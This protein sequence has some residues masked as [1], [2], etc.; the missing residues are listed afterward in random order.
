MSSIKKLA[1]DLIKHDALY[2][3]GK[4]VISDAEYDNLKNKVQSKYPHHPVFAELKKGV[5]LDGLATPIFTEWYEIFKDKPAVVVQPKI[6]GCAILLRY[7]NGFLANAWTR[8]GKDKLY[9]LTTV[10]N[11]PLEIKDKQNDLLIRGELYGVHKTPAYSQRLASGHLRKKD[12][13][14]EGLAF[15]AFEI[16]DTKED[17][18]KQQETLLSLGFQSS[19]LINVKSNVVNK[20]KTL[21]TQWKNSQLFSRFP[22]DGIVVRLA[23]RHR[24]IKS[25][26]NYDRYDWKIA[27]KS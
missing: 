11:I 23:D 3:A 15:C 27:L 4:A 16:L 20:V 19:G 12:P 2:R 26:A 1:L 6:D 14:G 10:K 18:S 24:Q 9:A 25:K 5:I 17:P 21:H 13:T 22:T 7:S 8:K